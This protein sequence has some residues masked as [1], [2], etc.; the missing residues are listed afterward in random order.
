MLRNL[1]L[2][3][4][5]IHRRWVAFY[6]FSI[7]GHVYFANRFL[8]INGSAGEKSFIEIPL[9]SYCPSDRNIDCRF[10]TYVVVI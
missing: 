5:N 1:Y 4:S 6:P 10:G 9:L 2:E 8:N 7:R 3:F